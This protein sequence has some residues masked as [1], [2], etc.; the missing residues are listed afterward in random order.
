ML[1]SEG[2]FG[3]CGDRLS[4]SAYAQAMAAISGNH[5]AM[6]PAWVG[7]SRLTTNMSISVQFLA[8]RN[9]GKLAKLE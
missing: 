7:R 4:D 3:Y 6:N 5:P 1:I 2:W 8:L 9:I